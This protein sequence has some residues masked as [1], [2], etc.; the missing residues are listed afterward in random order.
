[1]NWVS[2]DMHNV[3]LPAFEVDLEGYY[4]YMPFMSQV[5]RHQTQI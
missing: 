2:D 3:A 5:E 1:M 4:Y